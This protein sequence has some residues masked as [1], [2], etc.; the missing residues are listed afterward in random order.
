MV[1]KMGMGV[2]M[3]ATELQPSTKFQSVYVLVRAV[4]ELQPRGV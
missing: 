4:S 1:K 3:Y 2:T